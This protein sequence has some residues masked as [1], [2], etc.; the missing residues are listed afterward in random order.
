MKSQAKDF[1]LGLWERMLFLNATAIP[2]CDGSQAQEPSMQS[3]KMKPAQTKAGSRN[4][5]EIGINS[6]LIRPDLRPV[7]PDAFS[8]AG[9]SRHV[10]HS[11]PSLIKQ[12]R[13]EFWHLQSW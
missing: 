1:L 2:D 5:L 10:N 9:L 11:F 6:L 12:I 3:R 4:S 8:T 13:V 7:T